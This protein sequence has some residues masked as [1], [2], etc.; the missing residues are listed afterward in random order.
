MRAGEIAHRRE[1]TVVKVAK[2]QQDMR[3]D[4]PVIGRTTIETMLAA[5]ATALAVTAGKTLIFD[6][7]AVVAL[8]NRHR[9]TILGIPPT[10]D[11]NH[12]R[13]SF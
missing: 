5:G 11:K 9:L 3:F 12:D 1:L 2:P 8:A 13:T 10:A 6:R 4:V 7:D